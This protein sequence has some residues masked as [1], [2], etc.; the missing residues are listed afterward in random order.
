[1]EGCIARQ[2]SCGAYGRLLRRLN[3]LK[4][5]R[6]GF[7]PATVWT[8]T[9]RSCSPRTWKLGRKGVAGAKSGRKAY[10]DSRRA[11]PY[12]AG[13]HGRRS[14]RAVSRHT[15]RAP[16]ENRRTAMKKGQPKAGRCRPRESAR[17]SSRKSFTD[18]SAPL[19]SPSRRQEQAR[20]PLSEPCPR[21]CILLFYRSHKECSSV[22]CSAAYSRSTEIHAS[23]VHL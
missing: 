13:Q 15:K 16:A 21:G 10:E 3:Q 14:D 5:T 17:L 6:S 2:L 12:G 8:E 20:V 4:C 19:P 11:P 9:S 7:Q 18:A 23:A 22:L 1:M